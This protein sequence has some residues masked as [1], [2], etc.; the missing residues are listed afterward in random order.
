MTVRKGTVFK[1]KWVRCLYG[2]L[3]QQFCKQLDNLECS[4][5]R[6]GYRANTQLGTLTGTLCPWRERSLEWRCQHFRRH[7]PR[8]CCCHLLLFD[9][10]DLTTWQ[11]PE[12]PH[13]LPE[14]FMS[15]TKKPLPCLWG[16]TS[17][18]LCLPGLVLHHPIPGYAAPTSS[19]L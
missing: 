7:H 19:R 11:N 5:G 4:V 10:D 16:S 18:V 3:V 1:F 15:I 6:W 12:H 8:W 9:G 14:L 17:P 13:R 2:L